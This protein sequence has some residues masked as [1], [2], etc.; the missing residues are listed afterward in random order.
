MHSSAGESHLWD[1]EGGATRL[2]PDCH[3]CALQDDVDGEEPRSVD[4]ENSGGERETEDC[5]GCQEVEPSIRFL[6]G[7]KPAPR[8]RGTLV[9]EIQ[10]ILERFHCRDQR[11][12]E[13]WVYDHNR[14]DLYLS[15]KFQNTSMHLLLAQRSKHCRKPW[16]DLWSLDYEAINKEAIFLPVEES[17]EWLE[18]ILTYNHIDIASFVQNVFRVVERRVPK[19]NTLMFFGPPNAGKTLIANSIGRST[20]YFATISDMN[21]TGSFELQDMLYSRLT[22]FN[23]PQITDKSVE[24]LKNVCEG[25]DVSI[26]VK[27][28]S[29]QSLP[30]TPIIVTTNVKFC[31]NCNRREVHAAAFRARSFTYDLDTFD[32]LRHCVG[33]LH[34]AMWSELVDKYVEP[35]M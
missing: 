19:K 2:R 3:R 27:Y 11:A 35:T 10:A 33:D 23:E 22:I 6:E 13:T 29:G 18:K 25:N 26:G 20:H 4:D 24:V 32:E 30:R 21:G 17:I 16:R 12:L 28:K 31:M 15:D 1:R 8:V 7:Q 34:P 9:E 14:P 5:G